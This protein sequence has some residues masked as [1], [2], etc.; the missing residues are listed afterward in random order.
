MC[1]KRGKQW[2]GGALGPLPV[3]GAD[4]HAPQH[5][6]AAGSDPD[7]PATSFSQVLSVQALLPTPRLMVRGDAC[8]RPHIHGSLQQEPPAG[9]ISSLCW[10]NVENTESLAF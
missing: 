7:L 5:S 8:S 2:E 3:M 6:P 4:I 1:G 10:F 9:S